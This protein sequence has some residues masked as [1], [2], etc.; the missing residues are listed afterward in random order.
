MSGNL[1]IVVAASTAV[2]GLGSL[3]AA[4]AGAAASNSIVIWSDASR[5]PALSALFKGG[6]KGYVVNVVARADLRADL[7]S[8]T[9][10]EAPDVI[11]GANAWVGGLVATGTIV[12]IN[13]ARSAMAANAPAAVVGFRYGTGI[14]GMPY[15]VDN[16][17]MITNMGLVKSVPRTFDELST[18]ALA[19]KKR[20]KVTVPF[21]IPGGDMYYNEPLLTGLGGYVFGT[22]L[23]G[24]YNPRRVGLFNP[25]FAKNTRYIDAW[26]ASGLLS[27]KVTYDDAKNAFKTGKSPFWITGAGEMGT[28]MALKFRYA[29]TA[30]PPIIS[31]I[32]PTPFL[33]AQ[34]FMETKFAATHGVDA[35]AAALVT[36]YIP[37]TS[38]Q[39]K[40]F[41]L[42]KDQRLPANLVANR[43][44][45][46]RNARLA[47]FQAAGLGRQPI[48]NL[49]QMD[50]VVIATNQAWSES[51]AGE[52]AAP[53]KQVWSQA[54]AAVVGVVG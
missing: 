53:A 32:T 18:Q 15:S 52:S 24:T 31:G 25:V 17:A 20:G 5:A 27:S 42:S 37:T 34:G 44:A 51:F 36:E 11:V 30:V 35:G 23:N 1:R 10:A 39:L 8:V 26:N 48:P 40:I 3:L 7:A 21:A 9:E 4:P 50:S 54:A 13:P 28:L 43:V 38:A 12:R 45:A 2:I 16:I 49:P 19:L 41:T 6:Y 47:A 33:D 29:I 22:R 14:Y 46:K